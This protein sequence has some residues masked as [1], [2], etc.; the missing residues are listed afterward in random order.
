MTGVKRKQKVLKR[1]G[2][3]AIKDKSAVNYG[4]KKDRNCRKS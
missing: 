3:Y 2:Y 4:V 1:G